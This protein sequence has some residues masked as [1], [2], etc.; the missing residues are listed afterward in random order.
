M[1][2][3]KF[4]TGRTISVT[5]EDIANAKE[6]PIQEAVLRALKAKKVWVSYLYVHINN[7]KYLLPWIA[8]DFL[9]YFDHHGP[10]AVK[11]MKFKIGKFVDAY[12]Y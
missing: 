2:A 11:P 1:A 5:K 8:S 7:D 4:Y 9:R 10:S 3:K 6:C 12:S